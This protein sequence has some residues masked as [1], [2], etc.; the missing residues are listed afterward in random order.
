MPYRYLLIRGERGA[1]RCLVMLLAMGCRVGFRRG[2]MGLGGH[3]GAGH[4]SSAGDDTKWTYVNWA[5]RAPQPEA[6]RRLA[7]LAGAAALL[8]GAGSGAGAGR[9]VA[10]RGPGAQRRGHAGPGPGDRGPSVA[11]LGRRRRLGHRRRDVV[12]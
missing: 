12:T 8:V 5:N 10:L 3:P 6:A 4:G 2:A 7:R 1:S 11:F 9:R